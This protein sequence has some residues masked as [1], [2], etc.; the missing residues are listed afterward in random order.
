MLQ[1]EQREIGILL[2][3]VET[4]TLRSKFA[5]YMKSNKSCTY[6]ITIPMYITYVCTYRTNVL[7]A[8]MC[9][10]IFLKSEQLAL[11]RQFSCTLSTFT[12]NTTQT[13]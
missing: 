11:S 13:G 12:V 9:Y 6:R 3:V 2:M 5:Q 4:P 8:T 7:Q 10:Y 1:R